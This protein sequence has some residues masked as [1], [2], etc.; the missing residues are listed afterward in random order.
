MDK[1]KFK[2]TITLNNGHRPYV[3]VTRQDAYSLHDSTP[4]GDMPTVSVRKG[5]KDEYN[6]YGPMTKLEATYQVVVEFIKWYNKN[7]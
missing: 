7:S 5:K 3:D 4:H 1:W 2:V 6:I